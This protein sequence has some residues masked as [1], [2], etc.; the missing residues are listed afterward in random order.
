MKAKILGLLAVG[1]LATPILA[2]ATTLWSF[3]YAGVGVTA[4]G[5]LQTDDTLVN[6]GYLVTNVSGSRNSEAILGVVDTGTPVAGAIWDNLLFPNAAFV[7][8]TGGLMYST[9]SGNYNVCSS[10]PPNI[11]ACGSSGYKEFIPA[12]GSLGDIRFS[13]ARVPEP[14]T[15]ALLGFGLAG[16]GLSRRRKAA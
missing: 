14:G 10:G 15:L 8:G 11:A 5:F 7:F 9:A 12:T 4:S 6:G 2:G 13:L 16:L 3:S 1:L